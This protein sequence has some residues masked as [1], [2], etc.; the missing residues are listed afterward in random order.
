M[1]PVLPGFVTAAR[2]HTT[3]RH[4]ADHNR[5]P[6]EPAV[7]KPFNRHKEAVEVEVDYAS[8]AAIFSIVNKNHKMIIK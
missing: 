1:H 7:D 4:A 5:L 3:A 2:H 6:V 8:P